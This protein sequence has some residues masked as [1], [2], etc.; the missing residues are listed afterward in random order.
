MLTDDDLAAARRHHYAMF[1]A[2]ICLCHPAGGKCDARKLLD[3][4]DR[5]RALLDPAAWR[6]AA[7]S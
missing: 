7:Q 5:L 4:V 6:E 3:E 1:D 2:G